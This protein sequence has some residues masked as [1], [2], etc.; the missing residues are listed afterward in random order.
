MQCVKK[1]PN[2][3]NSNYTNHYNKAI[4]KLRLVSLFISFCVE[5]TKQDVFMYWQQLKWSMPIMSRSLNEVMHCFVLFNLRD[6]FRH[7]NAH[8]NAKCK[9][10]SGVNVSLYS[11]PMADSAQLMTIRFFDGWVM[12]EC[13]SHWPLASSTGSRVMCAFV[14][15]I[16]QSQRHF[17]HQQRWPVA[18]FTN[19]VYH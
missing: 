2:Q 7:L 12:P 6:T 8:A 13:S 17:L 4:V 14:P 11:Y 15:M 9:Q 16:Y 3:L 5:E 10:P 18:P 1:T 19:M